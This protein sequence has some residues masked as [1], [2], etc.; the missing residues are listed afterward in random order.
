MVLLLIAVM[1]VAV[2][3]PVFCLSP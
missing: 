1:D 3:L 2:G